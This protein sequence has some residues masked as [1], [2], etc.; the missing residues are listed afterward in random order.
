MGDLSESDSRYRASETKAHGNVVIAGLIKQDFWVLKI[1]TH[2]LLERNG[3]HR[4]SEWAW[5]IIL[6]TYVERKGS[7]GLIMLISAEALGVGGGN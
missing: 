2:R 7:D 6:E 1:L 4:P 5:V 3:A